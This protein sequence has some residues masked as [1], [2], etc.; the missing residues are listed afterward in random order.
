MHAGGLTDVWPPCSSLRKASTDFSANAKGEQKTYALIGDPDAHIRL[1][2]PP[3]PA[4]FQGQACHPDI[5]MLADIADKSNKPIVLNLVDTG[6][7]HAEVILQPLSCLVV[8]PFD[9]IC[10]RQHG[11][12]K[13]AQ[14]A[15]LNRKLLLVSKFFIFGSLSIC[16]AVHTP[17]QFA[18]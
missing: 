8:F 18:K 5:Q 4:C 10:N 9:T 2:W 1:Y 3:G 15:T 7:I 17:V 6:S 12:R 14:Y 16:Q 13:A 11:K